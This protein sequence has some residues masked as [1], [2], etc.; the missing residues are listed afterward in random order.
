M[1]NSIFLYLKNCSKKGLLVSGGTFL[2]FKEERERGLILSLL[3]QLSFFV[4]FLGWCHV[5]WEVS[6]SS[7]G[8]LNILEAFCI[9]SVFIARL[10]VCK[11]NLGLSWLLSFIDLAHFELFCA[12]DCLQDALVNFQTG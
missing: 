6:Q 2:S 8:F 1:F 10:N 9:N 12:F 5:H 4:Y 7:G 3:W 11:L